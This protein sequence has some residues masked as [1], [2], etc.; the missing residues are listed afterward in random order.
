MEKVFPLTVGYLWNKLSLGTEFLK[1]IYSESH[2]LQN[3]ISLDNTV[4]NHRTDL[5]LITQLPLELSFPK[6]KVVLRIAVFFSDQRS[7]V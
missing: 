5:P 4:F 2:S 3:S 1:R 6:D 7:S